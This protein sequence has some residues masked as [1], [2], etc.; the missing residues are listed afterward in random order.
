MNYI[1]MMVVNVTVLS[2]AVTLTYGQTA[3]CYT[4]QEAQTEQQP[5]LIFHIFC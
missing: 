4:T 2:Q 3:A 1:C 5:T